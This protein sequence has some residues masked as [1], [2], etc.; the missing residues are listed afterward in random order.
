M[1]LAQL[2]WFHLLVEFGW[3]VS[4]LHCGINQ[5]GDFYVKRVELPLYGLFLTIVFHALIL[6]DAVSFKSNVD[7]FLRE[8]IFHHPGKNA[9]FQFINVIGLSRSFCRSSIIS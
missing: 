1:T 6:I 9:V 3:R 8:K 2:P 5:P 7:H 4:H